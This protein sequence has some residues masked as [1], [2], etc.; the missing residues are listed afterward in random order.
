MSI[1]KTVVIA[2]AAGA[3]T[4]VAMPAMALENEFHGTFGARFLMSNYDN[5][6]AATLNPTAYRD[7]NKANNYFEQRARLQ[8]TAKANDD[9]KLVTQF[10]IDSKFGGDK[11]GKYGV[12]SDA[13]VLDADGINFETK[14]VYLDFN[15]GKAVNVKTGIQPIKD[16]FKG[17]FIDADVA[18]ILVT[19]K[20]APLTLSTGYYRT[21]T[22]S[23]NGITQPATT[24][25]FTATSPL[26]HDNNDLF[27]VDAKFAA[28][29]DVSVGAAYYL[30]ANYTTATPTTVHMFGLN[31]DAKL[32]P[33]TLSGFF[34]AETGRTFNA[35][36]KKAVSGYAGNLA[37]KMAIGPGTLRT[38]GLFLSGDGNAANG[39]N[40]AWANAGL[41]T[42][43]ESNLWIFARTGAGGTTTDR[44]IVGTGGPGNKGQWLYTL[45]YDAK[46]TPK[47]YA[48]A[49]L[50]LSWVAKNAGAPV[51]AKT[52]RANASNFQGT[53]INIETGYKVYD[54]LTAKVQAAYAILGGYYK[55]A[56]SNSIATAVKDPENPYTTRIML[57]YVF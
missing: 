47:L 56:A 7:D 35:G 12:S 32:G 38:A 36:V 31:A 27:M 39:N 26:G 33:A 52:G 2:A 28:S 23:S 5:G 57:S 40:T 42:Y 55:G 53:E 20:L 51:D 41:Q 34:A 25:F 11:T 49:N 19:T 50:G 46:I 43:G 22:E 9:L 18:G 44:T 8:Y 24:S 45:G 6:G 37:A 10:E 29:K 15:L 3:L 16:A 54:N 1:K 13:G 4:A 21:A 14:H 48:N 30:S 17:V